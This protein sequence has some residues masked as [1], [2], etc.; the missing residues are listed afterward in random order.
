MIYAVYRTGDKVVSFVEAW[1]GDIVAAAS[2]W[3]S[4]IGFP[5]ADLIRACERFGYKWKVRVT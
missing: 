3:V 2:E 1:D 4:Y 5:V